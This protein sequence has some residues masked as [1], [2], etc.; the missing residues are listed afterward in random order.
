MYKVGGISVTAFDVS[1]R[2][3]LQA[4]SEDEQREFTL[5]QKLELYDHITDT[6]DAEKIEIG[7]FVNPNVLPIFDDTGDLLQTLRHRP[8]STNSFARKHY[9]L[10]PNLNY[11][12]A[13]LKYHAT[14]FSFLASVSDSFQKKNTKMTMD[15]NHAQL[16]SML[17]LLQQHA[18]PPDIASIGGE[19]PPYRV[20]IYVSCI[21]DCPLEGKISHEIV[22]E[23][24]IALMMFQPETLCLSDTCGTITVEA[25]ED[26]LNK[27]VLAGLDTSK[28][29][30][31]LHVQEGREDEIERIIHC[32][33]DHNI[34][35]FDVSALT[36]GGCSVTMEKDK[37]APNL[38]YDLFGKALRSYETRPKHNYSKL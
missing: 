37:L 23:K 22:V 7:S 34:T 5:Q 36:T 20:R 4:L 24:L 12:K 35:E 27:A 30:L 33:L 6:H 25:F 8:V 10:V 3:G 26:I 13:A 18:Y 16:V 32:A 29:S 21:N 14:H 11:L 17:S 2:D 28:F 31:H 9:V 19:T 38:S 15:E 1:L